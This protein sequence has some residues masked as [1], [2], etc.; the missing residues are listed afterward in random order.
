MP[1]YIRLVFLIIVFSEAPLAKPLFKEI[2][3][4]IGF[5]EEMR[6]TWEYKEVPQTF[7]HYWR[8]LRK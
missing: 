4:E 3:L 1:F 6:T 5:I 2:L 7:F 8:Y